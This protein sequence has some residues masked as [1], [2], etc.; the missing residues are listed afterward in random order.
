VRQ[1]TA[2]DHLQE[3]DYTIADFLS[4]REHD[5]VRGGKEG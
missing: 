1:Q 3:C 2:I 4:T 5:V